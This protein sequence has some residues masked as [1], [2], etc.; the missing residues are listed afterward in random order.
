LQIGA[1]NPGDQSIATGVT[2]LDAFATARMLAERLTPAHLTDLRQM[3]SNP[4]MMATLGGVPGRNR[5]LGLS[6]AQ[7]GSLG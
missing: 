2:T 7:P 4:E 5:D 1:I 6:R 3:D